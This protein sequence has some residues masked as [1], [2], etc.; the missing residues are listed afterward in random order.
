MA[1]SVKTAISIQKELFQKVNEL[2]EELHVSRS[3]LFVLAV[4]DFIKK[5]ENKKIISQ[6]NKAFCDDPD[7]SEENLQNTMRQK[8]ARNLKQEPW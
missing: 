5:N 4:Q 1:T 7:S 3:K 2:A 8:Q 6:I